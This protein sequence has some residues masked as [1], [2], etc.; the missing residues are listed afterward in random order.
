[1]PII[2]QAV[3]PGC[4]NLRDDVLLV[5]GL[6]RQHVFDVLTQSTPTTPPL[7]EVNGKFDAATAASLD[8]YLRQESSGGTATQ[9]A[10]GSALPTSEF[11]AILGL[12][13]GMSVRN[14]TP[15]SGGLR[16]EPQSNW[17]WIWLSRFMELPSGRGGGSSLSENDLEGAAQELGCETAAIK[18]V[19]QVEASGSGWLADGRPKILF[20]AHHFSRLS[21]PAHYF[22]KELPDI[23]S[24]KWNRSLYGKSGEHQYDRLEKA[25]GFDRNAALQSASYGR[26]Q[27]MG[28]NY[29]AAG[30][31]SVEAMVQAMFA[32]ETQ[33]LNAFVRFLISRGL[34]KHL[35]T[36]NWAAF[37]RGYNG[38][39]YA[40]NHYDTKLEAAYR[41]HAK[42]APP[43]AS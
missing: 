26:F 33:H 5:Q 18:A 40:V 37:A 22:D 2:S 36:K 38:S 6:L 1:M 13:A 32:S 11:A 34:H 7:P 25:M 43:V 17:A 14:Y 10:F 31:S 23:S 42:A 12:D 27:I 3:G 19:A 39:Q 16:L 28:F 41:K 8:W 20:E 30:F 9:R 4:P 15:V 35:Q 29:K 21:W 24:R